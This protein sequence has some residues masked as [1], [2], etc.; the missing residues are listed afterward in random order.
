MNCDRPVAETLQP[1]IDVRR[2]LLIDK[3][4]VNKSARQ[5]STDGTKSGGNLGMLAF[6][7]EQGHPRKRA[8]PSPRRTENVG[9]LLGIFWRGETFK[10]S[11]L[12]KY[13]IFWRDKF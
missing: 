5:Y 12:V 3:P 13:D 11:L 9:Q 6:S 4:T 2:V 8:P 10:S 7:A 1:S